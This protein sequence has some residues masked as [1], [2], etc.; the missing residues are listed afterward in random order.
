VSTLDPSL[1][2]SLSSHQPS[3]HL[4]RHHF[5]P[6]RTTPPSFRSLNSNSIDFPTPA[7]PP[8]EIPVLPWRMPASDPVPHLSSHCPAGIPTPLLPRLPHH[9]RARLKSG[10]STWRTATHVIFFLRPDHQSQNTSDPTSRSS[11][12]FVLN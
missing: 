2:G 5:I 11:A 1:F 4:I 6:S 12:P 3:F 7:S 8:A 9:P 10:E